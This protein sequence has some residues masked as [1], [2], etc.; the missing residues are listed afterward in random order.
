V[1]LPDPAKIGVGQSVLP[2]EQVPCGAEERQRKLRMAADCFFSSSNSRCNS[3]V[4][5]SPFKDRHSSEGILK[6]HSPISFQSSR[7]KSWFLTKIFNLHPSD[8]TL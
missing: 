7:T 3:S 6:Q 1:R 5:L 8:F 2:G 4:K